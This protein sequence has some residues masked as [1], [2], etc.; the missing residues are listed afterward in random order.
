[1]YVRLLVLLTFFILLG[2]R[3]QKEDQFLQKTQ[4][5]WIST[6]SIEKIN[7]NYKSLSE[8]NS[9]KG[10]VHELLKINF[11][12][13]NYRKVSDCV[14]YKIPEFNE[15]VLFIVEN[16][17]N[18]KCKDLVADKAYVK[19]QNIRNLG[20]EIG[21]KL[22]IKIDLVKLKYNLLNLS[23]K[24]SKKLLSSSAL[25]TSLIASDVEYS[26]DR[27][28]ELKDG[29]ICFDI[30]D[31]CKVL[32]EDKCDSCVGSSFAV[33]ASSCGV[34]YQRR[35]GEN[36]CGTKNN[37]ACIRGFKTSGVSPQNYCIN[38]SPVG[39]CQEGLRVVCENGTL[40]CE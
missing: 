23:K 5:R 6:T 25:N 26:L 18:L 12:D 35:C 7:T 36:I 30:D 37:P 1:M 19:L 24:R 15:G 33:I 28:D 11:L 9:P 27:S 20:I 32:I 21:K 31:E 22:I 4:R 29:E 13:R 38:D 39:F 8:V 10:T 40:I 17:K 16:P 3:S 14:F 34:K 2:C